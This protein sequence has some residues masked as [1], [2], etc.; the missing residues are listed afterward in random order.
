MMQVLVTGEVDPLPLLPYFFHTVFEIVEEHS[1]SDRQCNVNYISMCS[2]FLHDEST[3]IRQYIL[4]YN[5]LLWLIGLE[6]HI[7][8]KCPFSIW[9]VNLDCFIKYLNAVL[10]FSNICCS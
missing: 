1:F 8:C 7:K 3:V 9:L 5:I 4:Q 2:L 6:K 10:G